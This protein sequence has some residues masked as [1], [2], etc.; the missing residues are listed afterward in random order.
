MTKKPTYEELEQRV[1]ELEKE[2]RDRKRLDERLRLLSLTVEQSSEGIA[3]SDLKGNLKYLNDAF[4][5]MHGYSPEGLVGKNLSIFHSP[6]QLPVVD[7][8]NRQNKETGEFKGEIWHVRRDGTVFPAL[9]HNSLLRDEEGRPTGMIGTLRDITDRK[10]AD[11]ALRKS[12]KRF[13]TIYENAPVFI[14][15][16]DENGHCL[17]WNKHCREIYGWT[18]DELNEHDD[19]LALFYP[20]PAVRDEVIRKVTT[21]PDGRFREWHPVTKD[22]KTLT[23]MWA[24]FRLPDGM[25]FNLGYDITEQKQAQEML[26]KSEERLGT[27]LSTMNIGLVLHNPDRT[28]AWVNQW[29]RQMFQHGDPVG[30]VCYEF[31]VGMSSPCDACAVRDCFET[32]EI[33]TVE[34]HNNSNDRWLFS[35][36]HPMKNSANQVTQV[37]ESV[38]DITERKRAEEELHESDLRLRQ[39]SS[40]LI[41]AQEEER[42]RI[43]L[44]LHDEMGQL[45]TAVGINLESLAKG[46]PPEHAAMIKDKLAETLSLLEQAS[47]RVRD[48]SVDLRPS[49]LDDLGLLPTLRWHI[50]SYEKRTKTPVK[51][52]S[53]NL[54]ERLAPE[55]EIV[56]YRIMQESLNNIAK[57]ARAKKVKIRLEHK[58]KRVGVLIEDDGIGFNPDRVMNET[59]RVK[60]IGLLGMRERV[61]LLQGSFS[62]RSREGQGTSIFAEFPLH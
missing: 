12:E 50:N 9:M 37:L 16:F 59:T 57:H 17:L 24:N 46:F 8:A 11:E 36:A 10:R 32:G 21:N 7:S 2:A 18:I 51:F 28:V 33:C 34:S 62:V 54:G 56:L 14:N 30:R 39:L 60:G 26:R 47:D 53:V 52:E 55:V 35:I 3:V 45:L 20:D 61:N 4:A 19:P 31:F 40:N 13:R 58:N 15:T 5:N 23:T 27:I 22:G 25:T 43:S 42:K 49:M 29:V 48:L 6:E 38:M 41:S 1:D 44:E